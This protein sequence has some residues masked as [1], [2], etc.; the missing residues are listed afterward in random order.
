MRVN[1]SGLRRRLD[2]EGDVFVAASAI[3]P[4]VRRYRVL[5]LLLQLIVDH[6]D[7]KIRLVEAVGVRQLETDIVELEDD[8]TVRKRQAA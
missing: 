4:Q 8:V 5:Q 3:V 1:G 6:A 2:G 7:V